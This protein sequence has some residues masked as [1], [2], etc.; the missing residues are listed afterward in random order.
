MSDLKIS[1]IIPVYNIDKFLRRCVDSILNQSYSNL[2]LIL[3][4]DGSSDLSPSICDEYEKM[5]KRVKVIHIENGGL[6]NARNIGLENATGEYISFIDGDDYIDTKMYEVMMKKN[7]KKYDIIVCD[8]VKSMNDNY[9]FSKNQ[10]IKFEVK[11]AKKILQISYKTELIKYTVVWNKLYKSTFIK[12]KKFNVNIKYGEDHNF[13]NKLYYNTDEI[14]VLD[15]ILYCYYRGN[16]TSI[17]NKIDNF[18]ERMDQIN[19]YIDEYNYFKNI[20]KKVATLVINR[21]LLTIDFRRELAI[22]RNDYN[23][24]IECENLFSYW[25]KEAINSKDISLINKLNLILII[26]FKFIR[27]IENKLFNMFNGVK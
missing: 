6:S 14:L 7:I 9:E 24:Q 26:K 15:N 3:V 8:Y 4:D 16:T 19:S 10:D 1:V 22:E 11:N 25:Y 21:L 23:N 17:C 18:K 20:D 2:E 12:D 5:D 13:L 27:K